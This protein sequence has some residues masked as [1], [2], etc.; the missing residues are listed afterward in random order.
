MIKRIVS[1]FI[2]LCLLLSLFCVTASAADIYEVDKSAVLMSISP[3]SVSDSGIST[4]AVEPSD[5][6]NYFKYGSYCKFWRFIS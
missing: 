2:V 6:D 5:L 3:L 4:A 1:L